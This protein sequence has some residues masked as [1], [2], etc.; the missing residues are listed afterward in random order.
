MFKSI[1]S[2]IIF[3]SVFL[4]VISV[5]SAGI[6]FFTEFY[7]SQFQN[8]EESNQV[9]VEQMENSLSDRFNSINNLSHKL[10][11]NTYIDSWINSNLDIDSNNRD[12]Y[13]LT[14]YIQ[15]EANHIIIFDSVWQQGGIDSAYLVGENFNIELIQWQSLNSTKQQAMD[16]II[17]T[18]DSYPDGNFYFL[19]EYQDS[20]SV[21]LA[22]KIHNHNVSES[23]YLFLFL[24]SDFI[25]DTFH[26]AS[27]L[28]TVCVHLNDTVFFSNSGFVG[29][30]F[31]TL[32]LFMKNSFEDEV[33]IMS[34]QI[35]KTEFTL[36]L[37]FDRANLLTPITNSIVNYSIIMLIL[38]LIFTLI[39]IIVLRA[40]TKFVQDT[41]KSL[42]RISKQDYTVR[43]PEYSETDLNNISLAF[44]HMTDETVKLI[45]NL[46]E[47]ER[48]LKLSELD[49]L[50][51]QMNPHFLINTLTTIGT[52]ALMNGDSEVYE[53]VISLNTLL[54][55]SLNNLKEDNPFI[56][57]KEELESVEKYLFIHQIRFQ[58]KLIYSLNIKNPQILE[59]RIPRLSI[60]PIVEN[61]VIHGIES[62]ISTRANTI[63][64]DAYIIESEIK[65][66]ISDDG[67]GFDVKENFL[68]QLSDKSK[69][70]I[71]IKKTHN[72][73]KMIYGE[74]YGLE[75]K[76]EIGKGTT[77]T[78]SVPISTE[79]K[80][81]GE[82]EDDT[83]S[84]G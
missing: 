71:G 50:Q 58:D 68:K 75:I 63:S 32:D 44:N 69:Y 55:T 43:M 83:S 1:R 9:I 14:S 62:Q 38:L 60:Q 23:M 42:N 76:S 47:S 13:Q 65:I 41:V 8:I 19:Y 4:V 46:Y 7:N 3:S 59:Q 20:Y 66:V 52:A 78:I 56:T 34:N 15:N 18:Y 26:Y 79:S 64:I 37:A 27:D 54:N 81:F 74:K 5:L 73:L 70:H 29:K 31:N 36:S 40:H 51:S 24:D 45:D 33:F 11:S 67:C 6:W 84:S 77:V 28:S 57:I 35:E 25:S 72:R 82:E 30:D 61:A 53:M 80:K 16:D 39:T 12:F 10:I 2:K 21:V 17:F 22:K 49:L 48:L